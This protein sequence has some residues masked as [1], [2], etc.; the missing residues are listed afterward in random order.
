MVPVVSLVRRKTLPGRARGTR[1]GLT[2]QN[3]EEE[4]YQCTIPNVKHGRSKAAEADPSN[5]VDEC[6]C[7]NISSRGSRGRERPPLPVVVLAT[8]EKVHKENSHRGASEDH[9]AVA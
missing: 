3:E 6:I 9:D 2:G 8:E 7:K 4:A 5:P 1:S